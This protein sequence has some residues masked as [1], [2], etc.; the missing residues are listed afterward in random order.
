[1]KRL[2]SA[3]LALLALLL[4]A[5]PAAPA[6]WATEDGGGYLVITKS[7]GGETVY[8]GDDA[9]FISRAEHYSGLVWL[10]ISPDGATVYENNAA[11]E[12]FPGLEMGGFET[13]ELQLISIPY[14]MDGWY[15][16]TRFL[17][18]YGNAYLTDRAQITVL[19]GTVASPRV[20]MKSG[21]ARLT[22]GESR[23][24][25]VEAASPGGDE[26]KYQWYRSY[27]A[28]RNSGEPILGATSAD[29]TPPEELG[30]V[31]YFVGVWCVRG[32][33]TSTPIYTTPVAIVYSA[34]ESTPEPE[35]TPEPTPS[36]TTPPNRGGPNP[37]IDSSSALVTALG[38]LI[39]LTLLAVI[40]TVLI[41]HLIGRKQRLDEDETEEEIE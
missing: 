29:Y 17:D 4:A 39:V 41:L 2:F 8:E 31:F 16:Q 6:A 9:L 24:L 35:P 20:K 1:M 18:A 28:A 19:Q 12:A 33:D 34:P 25:S 11:E 40:A 10:I 26:L 36:P 13:E 27:S 14:T 32:R 7:P 21:G 15:V 3:I 37:L 5:F 30:Q 22:L 23:T 38:A